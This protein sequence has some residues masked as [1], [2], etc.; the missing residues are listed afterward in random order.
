MKRYLLDTNA[1]LWIA[2]LPARLSPPAKK[3]FLGADELRYSVVNFWEVGLK[4]SKGGFPDLEVL[5]HWERDLVAGLEEHGITELKIE[6]S[7]CRKIQDLPFHHQD[8]FDRMLIAQSL[9]SGLAV[10]G[11]DDRFDDY[12][13]E[14]IW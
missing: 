1:L 7:H 8:P 11:S 14:R 12:G 13:V 3:A 4:L 9:E 10:I 5:A 2:Y 6:I